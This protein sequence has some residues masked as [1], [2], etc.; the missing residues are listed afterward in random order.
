MSIAC[1]RWLV[2][3]CISYPSVLRAGGAAMIPALQ[4][5]ISRRLWANFSDAALTE[6][7]EQRSISRK[8]RET[9]GLVSRICA[10]SNSLAFLFRPLK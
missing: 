1:P 2:A 7:R 10:M 4:I 8:V 6:D 9:E 5:S 3:N